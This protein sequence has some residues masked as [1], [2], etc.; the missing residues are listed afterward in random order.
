ME[1]KI[2]I[3]NVDYTNDITLPLSDTS[4]LDESLNVGFF[5][6]S[7]IGKETP[8]KPLTKAS[9]EVKDDFG[10]TKTYYY[11]VA[12]DVPVE[13]VSEKRFNHDIA[14]IEQTKWLERFTG[15]VKT[16]TTPLVNDISKAQEFCPII[17]KQAFSNHILDVNT[18]IFNLK[19]PY[20]ETT[21]TFRFSQNMGIPKIGDFTR[22]IIYEDGIIIKEFKIP[23]L[24]DNPNFV[25]VD[26]N[27]KDS[28][29]RIELLTAE[30]PA[31][32]YFEFLAIPNYQPPETQN[33]TLTKVI[34]NL[35][36]TA[37][38]INT[39]EL[40][41]FALNEAQATEFESIKAPDFSL[42]GTLWECLNEI[43]KYLHAIP[44]LENE[45][46]YFDKIG[47]TEQ[48]A[49]DLSDYC[50]HSQKFDI[51]QFASELDSQINNIVN[52]DNE[53]QG[54][55]S[56]DFKT[57][58][59][60]T[61]NV[62]V[63]TN[64]C[65]IETKEPIEKIVS[66]VCGYLSTGE[67]VGDLTPYV[68]EKAEYDGLSQ[69]DIGYPMSRNFAIY[70]GQGQK[71]IKGLSYKSPSAISPVFQ[72]MSIINII[73]RK[74]GISAT[75]IKNEDIRN[76][77]FT[78]QYIPITSARVKQTKVYVED[79]QTTSMLDFNQ[80]ANK[81]NSVAYGE[82]M[83]GTIARLGNPEISK[84]YYLNDLSKLPKVGQV[85]DKN[86]YVS[87]V[88][89]EFYKDFVKCEVALS[90]NFNKLNEYVGISKEQR[91]YEISEKE[92]V[93]RAV[94]YADY[95]VLD[96]EPYA[97]VEK[98]LFSD[99][100]LFNYEFSASPYTDLEV[101]SIR[102]KTASENTETLLLPVNSLA[103]GNSLIFTSQLDDNYSAGNTRVVQNNANLQYQVR[104][105]NYLGKLDKLQFQI[106]KSLVIGEENY[107]NFV[108]N[109]NLKP[110]LPSEVEKVGQ[111]DLVLFGGG[112]F[113][114]NEDLFK[115]TDK[116]GLQ[117]LKDNREVIN[118][119]YQLNFVANKRSFILGQALAR[120]SHFVSTA[121]NETCRL[122]ILPNEIRQFQTKVD[123]TGA[124]QVNFYKMES[125]G[126][127]SCGT[128]KLAT[129][130]GKSWVMVNDNNELLFGQNQDV[131]GGETKIQFYFT[132]THKV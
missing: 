116:F 34:N 43:G 22:G 48:V 33:Y 52:T 11:F 58:R 71:H 82:N 17:E 13:I 84:L 106:G 109:G 30:L 39:N 23:Y 96:N 124:T 113:N 125:L 45:V 81:V 54:T 80:S 111:Q 98:S 40:P 122:F 78:L 44:R 61:G 91:F 51:E 121:R 117:L 38:C 16:N 103:M 10:N 66:L 64:N 88:K 99:L 60:E 104:Y 59:T 89:T 47:G 55:V 77:Q 126:A 46:I 85:V 120:D 92:A 15:I 132:F 4:T 31:T 20:F 74:L 118:F 57:L 102:I 63:E 69:F 21:I 83:K 27:L 14:L 79:L 6:A 70:Y 19:S 32:Y 62:N 8:F 68:F 7:Y 94:N 95:C 28:F 107:Q 1:F 36:T 110:K 42:K 123:L 131:I 49:S 5:K 114:T 76:L 127:S 112:Y 129:A 72:E 87:V 65:F 24:M 128:S 50:S 56:T 41:R 12:S 26:I 3:D 108:K 97:N 100:S 29:Y 119:T 73:A 37:E 86:Y 90:K 2:L 53:Q 101:D 67:Y 35:L 9:V 25:D 18:S 93:E 130:N 115:D 105:T 75:S